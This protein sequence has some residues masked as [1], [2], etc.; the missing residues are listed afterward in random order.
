MDQLESIMRKIRSATKTNGNTNS[1][2][3][4]GGETR[5]MKNGPNT[6]IAAIIKNA[7]IEPCPH[8]SGCL[9]FSH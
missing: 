4:P 8:T 7:T 5:P 6:S 1:N 2:G 9:I 3:I